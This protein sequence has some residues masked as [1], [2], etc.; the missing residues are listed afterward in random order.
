M[1]DADLRKLQNAPVQPVV[2]LDEI[3]AAADRAAETPFSDESKAAFGEI[4]AELAKEGVIVGDRRAY[5]ATVVAQSAAVLDGCDEVAK[6]HLE[7]LSDVL[8]VDPSQA[9]AVREIVMKI[10]NPI[11]HQLNEILREV[12][13]IVAS[14]TDS[15]AR[16]AAI[17]KLDRDDK[18][19]WTNDGRPQVKAI[20]D[21]L[22]SAVSAQER[23]AAWEMVNRGDA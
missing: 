6:H 12:N 23:D 17:G 1:F 21:V 16:M 22:G 2:S 19:L 14:A 10:A 11:G 20:E 18:D 13:E 8:W 5:K 15:S 7:C 4:F 9:N 3:D